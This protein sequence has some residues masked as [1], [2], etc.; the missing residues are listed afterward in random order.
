MGAVPV[1]PEG[2]IAQSPVAPVNAISGGDHGGPRGFATL[3]EPV[4]TTISR[5]LKKVATKLKHVLVPVGGQQSATLIELRDWDLWGP[6]LLC[7]AL[8]M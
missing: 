8:S 1:V 5:D 3:D 7:L 2:T 6:L 4:W